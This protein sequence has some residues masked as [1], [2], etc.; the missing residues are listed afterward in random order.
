MASSR[1]SAYHSAADD[2]HLFEQ[3]AERGL[4]FVD[5][6]GLLQKKRPLAA[7]RIK[8]GRFVIAGT[9]LLAIPVFAALPPTPSEGRKWPVGLLQKPKDQWK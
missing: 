3:F 4:Q 6:E 8:R 9:G 7:Y 5:L 1:A 2:D